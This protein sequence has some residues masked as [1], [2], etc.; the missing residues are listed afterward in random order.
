MTV[1]LLSEGSLEVDHLRT[2]I[3]GLGRKVAE[4]E[5]RGVISELHRNCRRGN[6]SAG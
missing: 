3:R 5:Y 2:S 1:C 4:I 6:D